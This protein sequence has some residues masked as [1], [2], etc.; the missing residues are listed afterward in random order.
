MA[1][2]VAQG[3]ETILIPTNS[4]WR[5][6][7]D[8]SNQG[9]D[10]RGLSY[11][12]GFWGE[13]PAELGYGDDLDG[14]PEATVVSYGTDP[15][16]KYI[17]TYFRHTFFVDDAASVADLT[18][19]LLRDDG[20]VV[21]LNGNEVFRSNMPEDDID[22]LTLAASGV[23]DTN[24]TIFFSQSIDPVLLIDGDNVIA[25]E[26]H[27]WAR[28]SS[29]ISFDLELVANMGPPPPL[30]VIRGPYLQTG[31]PN[32]ITVRWRTDQPVTSIVRFGTE[33]D[34]LHSIEGDLDETTEHEVRLSGLSPATRYFY[35]VGTL[36]ME[37][38][39]GSNYFFFTHPAPGRAK[40]T[41]VWV[42]GDPGTYGTG[43]PENQIG[44]RD[45]YYTF[46]A[47][48][49]TDVWL[50][51][52]DNAYYD[53]TD[54]NY[55]RAFFNI[56]PAIMRQTILWSTIGNHETGLYPDAP[57]TLPYFQIFTLPQNGEAGGV[58]SGSEKYYSFDYANIHFVCLD[59]QTTS[60]RQSTNSPMFTWLRADLEANTNMWLIAFW[61]HPPYSKGSHDSDTEVELREMRT[62]AVPILE[63]YGVDL[64]LGGHS[65]NYERSYLLNGHYGPMSSL[66]P[67]MI[68][69]SGSGRPSE[70]GPYLKPTAGPS[71]N[72][73]AVYV[74]AGSSGWATF[75]W[76]FHNAMYMAELQVGS[77]VLDIDGNR[78]DAK[79]LR[80]TGA[81]DDNFTII[82]GAAPEPLR[83]TT[84]RLDNG[85]A[86]V[87]WNSV[88]GQHYQV[89]RAT[90]LG[91]RDWTTVSGTITA[92][93]TTC[94][95][96]NATPDGGNHNFYQVVNIGN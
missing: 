17:T 1:A 11:W 67:A 72:A 68:K 93:G 60:L 63:S 73:G 47:N 61:H 6:L 87:W 58:A 45:A 41:R 84:L 78:L 3:A 35:S 83:I 30:R 75:Q 77:L 96:T 18:V 5:Y 26:I 21:Y 92:T 39:R 13:G 37:L 27:Q 57:L 2:C 25:V 4:V 40:P 71:P 89:Q 82:K 36:D 22:Y 86:V 19:R 12:D 49:Y 80:E 16:N 38:A 55:Q 70:T 7:D 42:I 94:S 88:A 62:N 44:V 91:A 28:D 24:E 85:Q 50:A 31:T 8:G 23:N 54:E 56:Y 76:G 51:L 43:Q 52:G 79:F 69:D 29:D 90:D 74:V 15:D 10:W 32:A 65:H 33:A 59:A 95:F 20:G 53:G 34:H 66:T 9:T 81:I 64:V 46:T 14:R 48:R